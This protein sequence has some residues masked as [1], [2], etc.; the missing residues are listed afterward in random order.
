[1]CFLSILDKI[2][3]LLTQ[4]P[5]GLLSSSYLFLILSSQIQ[6]IEKEA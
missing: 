4:R 6:F 3:V 1:M 2:T 5:V